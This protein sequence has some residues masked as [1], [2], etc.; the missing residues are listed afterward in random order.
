MR[1]GINGLYA[2]VGRILRA[3]LVEMMDVYDYDLLHFYGFRLCDG[4]SDTI[5]LKLARG[6]YHRSSDFSKTTKNI[7]KYENYHYIQLPFTRTSLKPTIIT[8]M[9]VYS[10]TIHIIFCSPAP[11][12]IKL[13]TK[14]TCRQHTNHSHS[15]SN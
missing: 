10:P 12:T 5:K 13:H 6:T 11:S 8:E 7:L 4:C 14:T 2:D 9:V 1:H 15:Q 3:N